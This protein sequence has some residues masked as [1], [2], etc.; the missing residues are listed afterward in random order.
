MNKITANRL[1][2]LFNNSVKNRRID[3]KDIHLTFE[4]A[5]GAEFSVRPFTPEVAAQYLL[6]LINDNKHSL[7]E[8]M[9]IGTG[10]TSISAP[11]TMTFNGMYHHQNLRKDYNVPLIT[12]RYNP[13]SKESVLIFDHFYQEDHPEMLPY[14]SAPSI[15]QMINALQAAGTDWRAV[16]FN[17]QNGGSQ[18]S[19]RLVK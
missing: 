11:L 15:Y 2:D 10:E 8:F 4:T 19:L 14:I 1:S 18:P 13:Q 7:F 17:A 5:E 6:Y 9:H 3:P 12:Y 16:Q